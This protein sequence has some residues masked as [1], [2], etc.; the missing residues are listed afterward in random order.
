M[1]EPERS[2]C[3]RRVDS[4]VFH[5]TLDVWENGRWNTDPAIEE[6]EACEF[7]EKYGENSYRASHLWV[8][9]WL[10]RT[11]SFCGGIHPDDCLKLME[12]GWEVE[13]T[14]KNYKRYLNPPGYS[15]KQ[16]ALLKSIADPQREPG[17][18]VPSVWSPTP[19]VKVYFYHF[20][21][22]QGAKFNEILARTR[23]E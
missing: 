6:K 4:P 7:T 22:E 16:Q 15:T 14:D 20:T 11:C 9:S 5:Q 18:G 23:K 12:E 17:E 8:W 3:A 19:P 2:N 1:T 10:P 13:G 21:P